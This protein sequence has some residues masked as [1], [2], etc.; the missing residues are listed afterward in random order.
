MSVENEYLEYGVQ[1]SLA[2]LG[3]STSFFINL[4][5]PTTF[6]ILGLLP[7]LYGYTAYISQESYNKA[8]LA[9]LTTLIF[10]FVGGITAVVAV[11]YSIGNVAVSAFSGGTEFNDFY[12]ST[13]IPLLLVGI[14]IGGSIFT[15]GMYDQ[16]FKQNTIQ[17]A[18]SEIGKI[19]QSVIEDSSLI[20][21]QKESQLAA[22]N[23][24]AK[25]SVLLTRQKVLNE[26]RPSAKVRTSLK[27]AETAV[28]KQ[29]YVETK[30]S[31]EKQNFDM[32]KRVSQTFEEK[33]AGQ[34][35]AIVIPLTSVFF[36]SLQPLIGI[37]TGIFGKIFLKI[38]S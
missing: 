27:E 34:R 15:Y 33:F 17:N 25:N 3:V 26:T 4:S 37:L 9:T 30:S 38:G 32:Q 36:F 13:T 21:N 16:D 22:I 12:S 14:I 35:F 5:N 28:P 18:G 31:M 19:S 1:L 24:T 29:I 10:S 20:E 6:L 11:L 23:Q 7:A 8:S 2:V